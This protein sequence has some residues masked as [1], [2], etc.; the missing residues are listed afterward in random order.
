MATT[1][2]ECVDMVN[3]VQA[4]EEKKIFGVG[5]GKSFHIMAYRNKHGADEQYCDTHL[6]TELSSRLLILEH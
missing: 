1:I 2:E 4:S 3:Q 5:H 6:T